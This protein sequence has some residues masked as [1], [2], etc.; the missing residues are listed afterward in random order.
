MFQ[1]YEITL[2][3]YQFKFSV[4]IFIISENDRDVLTS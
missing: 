3:Y 2:A 1:S 4:Y